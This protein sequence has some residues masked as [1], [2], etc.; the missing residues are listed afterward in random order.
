[1]GGVRCRRLA[2]PDTASRYAWP[3]SLLH[4]LEPQEFTPVVHAFVGERQRGQVGEVVHHLRVR[5][6]VEAAWD[7]L[8]VVVT[9]LAVSV[10]L[11]N[12]HGG[13]RG[14]E[15][16][17]EGVGAAREEA[18]DPLGETV[19]RLV[20]T[21]ARLV[22]AKFEDVAQGLPGT[23]R[24]LPDHSVVYRHRTLGTEDRR[25]VGETVLNVGAVFQRAG[26]ALGVLVE[27]A[28]VGQ[29]DGR[30]PRADDA[31]GADV[32]ERVVLRQREVRAARAEID[33]ERRV[34]TAEVAVDRGR[35]GRDPGRRVLVEALFRTP[36]QD[37]SDDGTRGQGGDEDTG[38]RLHISSN[39][40]TL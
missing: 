15:F 22:S 17:G 25:V 18:I 31:A 7:Q 11:R 24:H 33:A 30:G 10:A 12:R 32:A 5:S 35:E 14:C 20:H 1:M 34:A 8:N 29:A 28:Q 39:E 16:Q 27:F 21:C 23:P 3:L 13:T 40:R 4:G 9:V 2:T 37:A 26:R 36:R 6:G 19:D 38:G